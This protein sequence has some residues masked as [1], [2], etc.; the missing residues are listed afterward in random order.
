MRKSSIGTRYAGTVGEFYVRSG[1]TSN[2][3]PEAQDGWQAH[4]TI[5][6]SG[7]CQQEHVRRDA[8]P[9]SETNRCPRRFVD[10]VPGK[11]NSR[12]RW[13]AQVAGGVVTY[14]PGGAVPVL[15]QLRLA[16]RRLL[17]GAVAPNQPRPE[18]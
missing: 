6:P 17:G 8:S 4:V 16:A 14:R 13:V 12:C 5:G 18:R 9:V 7:S 1:A 10:V 3:Q 15:D 2:R 11:S